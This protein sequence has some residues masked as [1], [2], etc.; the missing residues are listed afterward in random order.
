MVWTFYIAIILFISHVPLSAASEEKL[1][2]S[3]EIKQHAYVHALENP[4]WDEL[5]EMCADEVTPWQSKLRSL[6]RISASEIKEEKRRKTVNAFLH[7]IKQSN[8]VQNSDIVSEIDLIFQSF[9][10]SI[11]ILMSSEDIQF[12]QIQRISP[13]ISKYQ[14]VMSNFFSSFTAAQQRGFD[15]RLGHMYTRLSEFDY[16]VSCSP[17]DQNCGKMS[18]QEM[19]DEDFK[20]A[21]Q[22]E[23]V[24]E[25]VDRMIKSDNIPDI[26][27]MAEYISV[28]E[29]KQELLAMIEVLDSQL[30]EQLLSLIFA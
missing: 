6:I 23:Q 2:P 3:T 26:M 11:D 16:M 28:S 25:Y 30:Y 20:Q 10:R 14:M 8:I 7:L 22:S 9:E 21:M 27:V 24:L 17:Y 18:S 4:V 5:S 15:Q 19:I 13:L 29:W 12:D 1:D